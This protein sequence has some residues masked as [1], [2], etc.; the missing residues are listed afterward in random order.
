[1]LPFQV[2]NEGTSRQAQWLYD[3]YEN[4]VTYSLLSSDWQEEGSK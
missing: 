4:I 2:I 1:M 3:H